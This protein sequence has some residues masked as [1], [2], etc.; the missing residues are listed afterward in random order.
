MRVVAQTTTSAGCR[1]QNTPGAILRRSRKPAWTF[2]S[3]ALD[4]RKETP[5]HLLFALTSLFRPKLRNPL[6]QLHRNTLPQRKPDR[7]LADLI[8]RKLIPKLLDQQTRGRIDRIVLLPPGKINHHRVVQFVRRNLV[9]DR[10]FS[11]R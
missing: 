7:P 6:N 4:R 8:L 3:C 10:L 11:L 5:S 9:R 1:K 2:S